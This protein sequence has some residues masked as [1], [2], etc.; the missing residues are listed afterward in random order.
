MILV[1]VLMHTVV[2]VADLRCVC[3]FLAVAIC[4]SLSLYKT[5][6]EAEP[7]KALLLLLHAFYVLVYAMSNGPGLLVFGNYGG[8]VRAPEQALDACCVLAA[9]IMFCVPFKGTFQVAQGLE[10][11]C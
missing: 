6:E 10:E 8:L 5:C 1:Q 2:P 9:T 7:S 3:R 11:T 4:T